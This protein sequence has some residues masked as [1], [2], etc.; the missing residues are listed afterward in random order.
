MLSAWRYQRA[1][2]R[3]GPSRKSFLQVFLGLTVKECRG[4]GFRIEGVG[5][6]V[7]VWE[8]SAGLKDGLPQIHLSKGR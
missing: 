7:R 1:R 5:F 2:A 4:P 6:R 3:P 8:E